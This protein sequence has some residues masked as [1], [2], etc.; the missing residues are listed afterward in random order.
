MENIYPV[1]NATL[2]YWRSELHEINSYRSSEILPEECDIVI[3]GAGIS[4]VSTA[5]HR[6]SDTR[7]RPALCSWK[8]DR[9]VL[10]PQG[11]IVRLPVI[12]FLILYEMRDLI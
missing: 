11:E 9:Y 10:R 6:L 7:T 3:I 5:Y 4:G 12:F 8:Q 2:P 1:V